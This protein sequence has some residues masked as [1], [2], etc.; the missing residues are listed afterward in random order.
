M[1][2]VKLRQQQ[3]STRAYVRAMEDRLQKTEAKQRQMMTFLARAMQNPGFIHQ[4][5]QNKEKHKELEEAMTKKRRRPIDQGP[6]HQRTNPIKPEPVEFGDYGFEVSELEA[7]ALEM[8]GYGRARK[9]QEEEYEEELEPL[10]TSGD[11]REL[12]QGFWEELLSGEL[13]NIP[14][15]E[16]GEDEDDINVLSARLGDLGS[17]PR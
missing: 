2:L 11:Y 15:P 10:E 12:D 9:D 17:S 5:V 4:L 3:Q 16:E 13:D 14:G 6:S 1:E 8:Q 7:L